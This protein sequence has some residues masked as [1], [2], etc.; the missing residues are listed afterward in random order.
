MAAVDPIDALSLLD[1]PV[2]KVPSAFQTRLLQLLPDCWHMFSGRDEGKNPVFSR[3]VEYYLYARSTES[4]ACRSGLGAAIGMVA[5][6]RGSASEEGNVSYDVKH[7]FAS[8]GSG[9]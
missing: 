9:L 3:P 7:F 5:H 2:G 8:D 6:G 4:T 1:F